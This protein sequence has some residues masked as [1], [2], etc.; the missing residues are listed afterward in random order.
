MFGLGY[1]LSGFWILRWLALDLKVVML[2]QL[3]DLFLKNLKASGFWQLNL[4]N[5][6]TISKY[7]FN[8]V[9]SIYAHGTDPKIKRS[10]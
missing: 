3:F 7:I 8:G 10:K 9:I 5:Y 1:L 4:Q 6:K 2:G